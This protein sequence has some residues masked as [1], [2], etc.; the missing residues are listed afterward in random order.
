MFCFIPWLL[1]FCDSSCDNDYDDGCAYITL[2]IMMMPCAYDCDCDVDYDLPESTAYSL[3]GLAD[4][5]VCLDP[6]T[7]L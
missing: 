1:L 4:C 3:E 5:R 6:P 2:I 7:T